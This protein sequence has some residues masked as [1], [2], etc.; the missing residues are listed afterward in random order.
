MFTNIYCYFAYH[1]NTMKLT[2]T[3]FFSQSQAS[4]GKGV[5]LKELFWD[6]NHIIAWSCGLVQCTLINQLAFALEASL[7]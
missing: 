3:L 6:P 1:K 7:M 2:C 4:P 5:Q